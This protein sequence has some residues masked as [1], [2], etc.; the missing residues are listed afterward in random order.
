MELIQALD[1]MMARGRPSVAV[2]QRFI[3]RYYKQR[4]REFAWRRTRDPYAV[5]VSEVMLQQTQTE[6]VVPK[7]QEFLDRFPDCHALA[8][9]SVSE[10]VA[11][12][13]GLGYYRRALNLRAAAAV[14]VEQYGGRFPS[15]ID[16][17]RQL[18]GIG[19][20]TAAAV[21]VFA[22]GAAVPMVETN[23]RTVFLYVYFP[24]QDAVDDRAISDL[25][26]AT[27]DRSAPREWFYALMDLGVELKRARP[28]IHQRSKHY[29][30]QSRFEG[31]HRQLRAALLRACTHY[32]RL[33]YAG[34]VA[35]L[36][37]ELAAARGARLCD[38]A[39]EKALQEL[40]REGFIKVVRGASPTVELA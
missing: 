18:P 15:S 32:G 36:S 30:R 8:R 16:E 4:G 35:H 24:Q 33:N 20:Y 6:R 2:F 37:Q 10:V 23:I 26:A 13:S 12:W 11:A 5:V 14:V 17:L 40:E 7:Y 3:R 19:A 22:F 27:L 1:R 28:G 21:A 39:I 31:S 25:V 34:L 38:S 29:A 9:A